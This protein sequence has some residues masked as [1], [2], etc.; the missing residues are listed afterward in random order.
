MSWVVPVCTMR[1]FRMIEMRSPSRSASSRSWLT[2]RMV[3]FTRACSASN[4]SCSLSRISGSSAENGSSISRMSAL[5]ANARARPTRCC[6]PPDSSPTAQCRPVREAH[7]LQLLRDDALAFGGRLAAQLE[8]EPDVLR[9][10]AP[11][12][13]RRTAG[14]PSR[15]A[16]AGGAGGLRRCSARRRSVRSCPRP[17]PARASRGSGH[18]RCAGASTCRSRTGPSSRRSRP[19]QSPGSHPRRR[20]SRRTPRRSRPA[21]RR[22]RASRGP[23]RA[24]GRPCVPRSRGNRMST[25][26]NSIAA[27][28]R[29]A[30]RGPAG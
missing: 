15:P 6:M 10:R 3:F 23:R 5:V 26:R 8:A 20:R 21:S 13:Q 12:Q 30:R 17:A 22:H 9:H 14:I 16:G 2:N 19:A 4:S 25:S 29:A 11:G 18:W 27:L 1:P 24:N 28:I 7:Q